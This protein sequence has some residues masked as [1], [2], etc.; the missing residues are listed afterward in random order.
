VTWRDKNIGEVLAMTSTKRR[1]SARIRA[2]I[3]R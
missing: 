2:C 3:T 1:F